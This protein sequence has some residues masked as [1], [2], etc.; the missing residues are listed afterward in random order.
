LPDILASAYGAGNFVLAGK[1]GVIYSS[2]YGKR[3]NPAA[4]AR[5]I[6]GL[7]FGGGQ[8]VA[9]GVGWDVIAPSPV[10]LTSQ[11]GTT[12]TERAAPPGTESLYAVARGNGL[13]VA[14]GDEG[15]VITSLNG[16]NWTARTS[17][18]SEQLLG[19]AWEGVFV[20]VGSNRTVLTSLDGTTWTPQT[21]PAGMGSFLNAVA[22]DGREFVAVSSGQAIMTSPD[23]AAWTQQSVPDNL[24][25]QSFHAVAAGNGTTVVVGDNRIYASLDGSCG[26]RSREAR[27]SRE[28]SGASIAPSLVL[29]G[30]RRLAGGASSSPRTARPGPG[31]DPNAR[32]ERRGLRQRAVLRRR[33]ERSHRLVF[34]TASTSE[35]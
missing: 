10:I 14:V 1:H 7:V 11:N 2:S 13:Y 5:D 15:H 9:V 30:S 27:P 25:A 19:V 28:L 26:S 23:G 21:A 18:T 17:G 31:D 12:W 16:I 4:G 20:A 35:T 29:P 32:V 3:I 22:H 33:M 34:T 8:F 24:P 6:R